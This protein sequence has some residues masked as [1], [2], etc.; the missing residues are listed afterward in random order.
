MIRLEFKD[1]TADKFWQAAQ[2]EHNV[3]LHWGRTGTQGQRKHKAFKNDAAAAS[4][5]Q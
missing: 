1:D 2:L 4:L 3:Y 5:L